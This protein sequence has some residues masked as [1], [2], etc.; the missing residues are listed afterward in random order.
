ML[1]V[2]G[3]DE[4]IDGKKAFIGK[5]QT[6]YPSCVYDIQTLKS[7]E[8]AGYRFKIDGKYVKAQEVWKTIEKEDKPTKKAPSKRGS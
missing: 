5:M 4:M 1:F 2:V 3:K 8:Q 6:E 7:M